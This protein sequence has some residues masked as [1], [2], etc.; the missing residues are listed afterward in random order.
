MELVTI[1]PSLALSGFLY[2]SPLYKPRVSKLES[3]NRVLATNRKDEITYFNNP[4]RILCIEADRKA[5]ATSVGILGGINSQRRMQRT[6]FGLDWLAGALCCPSC[7]NLHSHD[8]LAEMVMM[9][10]VRH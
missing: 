2:I 1:N 4:R 5:K 8:V 6:D 7:R 3:R 9:G 10:V